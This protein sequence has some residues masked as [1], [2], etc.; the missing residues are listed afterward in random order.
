[1]STVNVLRL[2]TVVAVATLFSCFGCSPR[3]AQDD[4]AR[5]APPVTTSTVTT[6]VEIEQPNTVEPGPEEPGSRGSGPEDKP[7]TAGSGA[8][9]SRAADKVQFAVAWSNDADAKAAGAQ[10]TKAAIDALDGPAKAVV[11]YTYYQD[12]DF[13][14]DEANRATACKADVD[15]E[16]SVAEAVA[17]AC[18]EVPNLGCRARCLTNGGT[19]LKNA[20]AVLAVAASKRRWPLLPCLSWAIGANQASKS[21]KR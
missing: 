9:T 19:L 7:A 4:R 14:P 1:M 8:V 5:V 15:A 6:P 11:F 18:G 12:P 21:L 2:M 3:A 13:V 10:A 16:Q 17:Q 20:V